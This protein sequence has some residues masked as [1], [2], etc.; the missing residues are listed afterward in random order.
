MKIA[1]AVFPTWNELSAKYAPEFP[2]FEDSPPALAAV[3]K[4]LPK[5]W[6]K[7]ATN[8][9][10]LTRIAMLAAPMRFAVFSEFP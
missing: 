6:K 2:S 9:I 10:T 1:N 5:L 8:T 4:S 7:I 3:R